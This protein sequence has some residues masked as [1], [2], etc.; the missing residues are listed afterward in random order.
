MRWM[1]VISSGI[2]A[3]MSTPM[4]RENP[5][6]AYRDSPIQAK[7][8]YSTRAE[9]PPTSARAASSS[10]KPTAARQRSRLASR[11]PTPIAKTITDRTTD[12]WVTESP[13]R[14]EARAT[15]SSSYT[16]PHAAQMKTVASTRK[17]PARCRAG[18][19][20]GPPGAGGT[21]TDTCG[22]SI[23]RSTLRQGPM[24]NCHPQGCN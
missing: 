21:A 7:V 18:G 17:R 23:T 24:T 19:G 22:A 11:E 10:P 15:S 12:A 9:L 4:A 1:S 5:T 2:S 6:S 8:A 20:A 13:I 3:P 14:Y 16:R